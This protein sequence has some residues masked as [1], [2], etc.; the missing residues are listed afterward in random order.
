MRHPNVWVAGRIVAEH[1]LTIPASDR[2]F[3]HGLGLFETLRTWDRRPSLLGR[4]LGRLRTSAAI[5]GLPLDEGALPVEASVEALLRANSVEGDAMLRIVLTG[6]LSPQGG[7]LLWMRSA[8]LP[9]IA[10]GGIALGWSGRDIVSDEQLSR[11]KTLNYWSRRCMFERAVAAGADECVVQS[12]DGRVLEASRSN[13]FVVRGGV[14]LTPSLSDPILPGIL[15]GVVLE[16]AACSGVVARVED[17]GP[18]DLQ[19][20]DEIFLTNAVRGIMPVRMSGYLPPDDSPF[21]PT[22][23]Y[24]APG[25]ITRQLKVEVEGWLRRG[26]VP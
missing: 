26:D 21:L 6:G 1:E 7:S 8:P 16:R 13:L 2:T 23:D 4:H 12:L 25:P 10:P 20:A 19:N 18:P 22:R 17:L 3:E 11:F 24:E 9:E 15:R 14:V 5:L